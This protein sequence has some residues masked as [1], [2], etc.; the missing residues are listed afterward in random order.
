MHYGVWYFC[1]LC[2]LTMQNK[3]SIMN[4]SLHKTEAPEF[5]DICQKMVYYLRK[6]GAF[7]KVCVEEENMK[8]IGITAYGIRVRNEDQK[9]LELHNIYGV[10]L[11]ELIKNEAEIAVNEYDKDTSDE[12]IFAYNM[13]DHQT[14]KNTSGQEIYDILYLRVK[15]GD[16]GEESEIVDSNTGIVTHRKSV[17]E[18][19]V[20]PFGCCIIVP[21]GE[22]SEGIVLF[23]SLG[24]NGITGV[25]KKKLNEYVKNIDGELR[26]VMNPIVPK[27]YMRRLLTNGVLRR[28]RLISYTIPEDDAERYGLDRG[29]KEAVQ[30]RVINRPIGFARNKF[31]RIMECLKGERTYD[32]IIEL[33]DFEIDDL[34][35]EFSFGKRNKTI[36]MKGLERLVV[37]EDISEDVLVENGHP[38]FQSLCENMKVIGEEY[39]RSK[40]AID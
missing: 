9:N 25:M 28:I 30:E 33:D 32:T 7:W 4:L 10:S 37:T 38:V 21:S 29:T 34:K 5:V 27:E 15:T 24:R 36:S 31:D 16:Y 1:A 2:E 20:M 13:I 39:L 6:C 17:A 18:A 23:Q 3:C 22:Y 8:S 40:G 11:I 19:D 35:M 26:A 14:I 12:N